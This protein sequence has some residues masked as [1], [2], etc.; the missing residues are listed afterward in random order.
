MRKDKSTPGTEEA[1]KVGA[2]EYVPSHLQS[3]CLEGE[4]EDKHRAMERDAW[5]NG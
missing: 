5:R 4:E 3:V 2:N 1:K